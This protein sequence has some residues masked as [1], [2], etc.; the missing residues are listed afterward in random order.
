VAEALGYQ[1]DWDAESRV[2]LCYP[3]GTEKPDVSNVISYVKGQPVEQPEEQPEE[4]PT[5]PVGSMKELYDKAKP[6]NGKPFSFSGWNF[7]P[8]I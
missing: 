1:V 4:T 3:K 8:G 7:N 2:V 6:I 5:A